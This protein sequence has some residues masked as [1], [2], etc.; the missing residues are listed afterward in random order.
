MKKPAN[1]DHFD[2]YRKSALQKNAA[3]V[4]SA[5]A[6]AIGVNA[7]VFGTDTGV[8]LQTSAVEY[9]AGGKTEA[10]ADLS[11]VSAGTGSDLLK[12]RLGRAATGV[13]EFRATLLSDADAVKIRDA[14]STD[15]DVEI[16]KIGNDPGYLLLNLRYAE[17]K[18]FAAGSELVTIAYAKTG[19]GKTVVNLA[20][21]AFVSEGVSYELSNAS[22]EF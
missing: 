10:E 3:I 12:L 20:E 9:A 21:T 19:S 5:F 17:P 14:F 22:I 2:A 4:V 16:V 18:D 11:I 15:Q 13:K 1:K 6:L 7:L 8:R